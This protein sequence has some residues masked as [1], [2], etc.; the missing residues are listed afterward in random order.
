M[1]HVQFLVLIALM[2]V[3][4][5]AWFKDA[6][7]VVLA[8]S[9]MAAFLGRDTKRYDLIP[10][11]LRT[12]S[13]FIFC[14]IFIWTLASFMWGSLLCVVRM[15]GGG[16]VGIFQGFQLQVR[17]RLYFARLVSGLVLLLQMI[18]FHVVSGIKNASLWG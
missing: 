18:C 12:N 10:A 15:F 9:A 1:K 14:A 11:T 7:V 16:V 13:G 8:L 17:S 6:T 5:V 4:L 2:F 3:P